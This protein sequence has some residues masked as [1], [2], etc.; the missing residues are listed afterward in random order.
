VWVPKMSSGLFRWTSSRGLATK[1][2]YCGSLPAP[3]RG[4]V[5]AL[6]V[7]GSGIDPCPRSCNYDDLA[8]SMVSSTGTNWLRE[9]LG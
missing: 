5:A 2:N 1:P 9:A 7:L 8:G 4:G 6:S 3:P